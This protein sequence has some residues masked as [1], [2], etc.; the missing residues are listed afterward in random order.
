[1]EV[2]VEEKC[3]RCKEVLFK[4][5]SADGHI[6]MDETTPLTLGSEGGR[7]FYRC[8][9]CNTKNEV[10]FDTSSHPAKMR[11]TRIID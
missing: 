5:V 1:M 6:F 11:I 4:K 10:T 7:S 3:L 2:K 8:P 9:I